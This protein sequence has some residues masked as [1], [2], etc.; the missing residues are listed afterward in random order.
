L[1]EIVGSEERGGVLRVREGKVKEERLNHGV[2]TDH[3]EE[4][5]GYGGEVVDLGVELSML[6]D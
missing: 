5:S 3:C 4:D 6:F 2:A 1:S